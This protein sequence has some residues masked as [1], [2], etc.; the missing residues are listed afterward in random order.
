MEEDRRK[1]RNMEA[2]GI[3]EWAGTE[4]RVHEEDATSAEWG[5]IM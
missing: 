2:D 1:R 5:A 4:W 3:N